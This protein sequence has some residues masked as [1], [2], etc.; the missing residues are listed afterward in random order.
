MVDQEVLRERER[1][2]AV[3]VIFFSFITVNSATDLCN[4]FNEKIT[5]LN[6]LQLRLLLLLLGC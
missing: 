6:I 2:T 4:F 1:N 3:N 5:K